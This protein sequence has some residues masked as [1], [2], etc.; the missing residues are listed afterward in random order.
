MTALAGALI[1][2]ALAAGYGVI[3]LFFL[4]FYR[5]TADRLF[6]FFAAAFLLLS[7]Q[8][9]LLTFLAGDEGA[10]LLLYGIRLFAFVIIIYAIV[11][12]NRAG[13]TR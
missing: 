13:A 3:A 4:R 2:G 8:R 12:R 1:S 9:I 6:G 7:V 10:G 5:Q 11:D